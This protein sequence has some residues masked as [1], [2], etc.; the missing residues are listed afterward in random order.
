MSHI[1]ILVNKLLSY[2]VSNNQEWDEVPFFGGGGA[3]KKAREA[4]ASKYVEIILSLA[5]VAYC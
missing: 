5:E 1:F 4:D 3:L 2:T